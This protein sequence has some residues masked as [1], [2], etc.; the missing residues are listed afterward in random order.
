MTGSSKQVQCHDIWKT[1]VIWRLCNTY[2]FL[3]CSAGD[4]STA[5]FGFQWQHPRN[6]SL[7]SWMLRGKPH[8]LSLTVQILLSGKALGPLFLDPAASR[9]LDGSPAASRYL[10]DSFAKFSW[11]TQV[12]RQKHLL[13]SADH[14]QSFLVLRTKFHWRL[15]PDIWITSKALSSWN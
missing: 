5:T 7:V 8:G 10:D 2:Q 1:G 9:Y 13:D 4:Y 11:D 14:S 15:F 12:R 6:Q 3:P